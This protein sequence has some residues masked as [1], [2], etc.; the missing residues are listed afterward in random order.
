LAQPQEYA[1]AIGNF[2]VIRFLGAWE[3]LIG[4]AKVFSL[5]D[6][7]SENQGWQRNQKL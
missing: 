7:M 1:P 3:S 2:L 6:L 4:M 5:A